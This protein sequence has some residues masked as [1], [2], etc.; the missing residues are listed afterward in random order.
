MFQNCQ[1]LGRGQWADNESSSGERKSGM[2]KQKKHDKRVQRTVPLSCRVSRRINEFTGL[3]RTPGL[4]R[5]FYTLNK[6]RARRP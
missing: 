5:I 3:F 2:W 4:A 1:V 6:W